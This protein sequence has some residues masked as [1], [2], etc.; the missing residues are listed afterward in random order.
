[1]TIDYKHRVQNNTKPTGNPHRQHLSSNPKIDPLKWMQI[2]ALVISS[3]VFLI[4]FRNTEEKQTSAFLTAKTLTSPEN[5]QEIEP[6]SEPERP[7]F[8]F[9]K[10]LSQKNDNRS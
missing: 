4:Y 9:Y 5:K 2:T 3:A 10:L 7:K 1:M 8:D 6:I